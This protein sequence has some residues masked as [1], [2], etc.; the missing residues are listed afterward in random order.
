MDLSLSK[1]PWWAQIGAFVVVCGGAAY[2]FWHFYVSEMAADVKLRQT[3]LTALRADIARGV[4]T[5]R[6]LPEFEQQV[7]QL[8]QRLENLK[9]VLPEEK[10]VADILRRIQGLATQSNLSIQ[11]FQPAPTVQQALYAEIPYR[12]EAEGTY[13]NLGFFFD[14]VSKFPRIINISQIE[15]RSKPKGDANATIIAECIAT[16]FVLQEAGA[17]GKKGAKIIPKQPS[18]GK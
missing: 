6:R 8:E 16:T 5:A 17:T 4:A 18:G 11:R 13:H 12:L 9:A 14:R 1:L 3:R 2:G 10:D 15:I 7:V